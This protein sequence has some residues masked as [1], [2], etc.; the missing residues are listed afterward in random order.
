MTITVH[1]YSAVETP[2]QCLPRTAF[3]K[4]TFF[5]AILTMSFA[6]PSNGSQ[7]SC[8]ERLMQA[9]A[10]YHALLTGSYVQYIHNEGKSLQFTPANRGD[11][12]KYVL[13]LR[14]QCGGSAGT[15]HSHGCGCHSCAGPRGRAMGVSLV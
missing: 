9:E 10:A 1:P 4:R 13:M 8:E 11:L 3:A 15:G 2:K 5:P 14:A 7:M 12:F 6:P